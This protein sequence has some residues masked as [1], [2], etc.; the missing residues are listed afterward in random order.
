[1]IRA[2]LD[3]NVLASGFTVQGGIP[4]RLLRSWLTGEWELIISEPIIVELERTFNKPYF[5]ARLT[6]QQQASNIDLLIRRGKLTPIT[7]QVSGVATHHE[8][9]LILATA[10]S[11]RVDYLVTG[12]QHLRGTVATYQGVPILSPRDFWDVLNRREEH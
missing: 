4:D 1:V 10:A 11:A 12:D 7:I 3:T 8:D 2:V 9:D 6:A 5:Q